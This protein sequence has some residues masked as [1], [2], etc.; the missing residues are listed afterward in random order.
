MITA[1]LRQD[2][3]LLPEYRTDI[4]SPNL[5]RRGPMKL[6]KRASRPRP[7]VVFVSV[8]ACLLLLNA[9]RAQ[10]L[11]DNIRPEHYVL[12][13]AP[14]LKAATYMGVEA[15]EVTIK[16]P[17][18]AITLNSIEIAFQ[19]AT[20]PRAARSRPPT[21]TLDNDK[22][23]ATLTVPKRLPAGKATIAIR[24]H[25]HP[26][27]RAARLLSLQDGRSATTPSRSSSHRRPARFP[28]FDEPAFKATFD[29]TLV[30]DKG[31]TA[32]SNGPIVS[33]TPGP[34]D[35]KHTLKF[36][37][38]AEDVHLSGRVPGRRLPVHL[39]RAGRRRHPRLR[40]A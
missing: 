37:H 12:G 32:I 30:I 9:A 6:Y 25:R 21:V 24:L 13:L 3:P 11:S 5:D 20:L 31:D 39:R 7:T 15:I 8:L 10:R 17:T 36:A 2:F 18:A 34:G 29:V 23:Q 35:G 14:D 28:C 16:Q 38:H 26:E 33:D 1:S 27:Q 22:Q 19:S 4:V 40:H